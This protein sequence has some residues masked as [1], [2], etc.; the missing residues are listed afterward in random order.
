MRGSGGRLSAIS[1]ATKKSP[2]TALAIRGL[3]YFLASSYLVSLLAK[4]GWDLKFL[5]VL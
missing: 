2:R 5:F 4:E 3:F 1:T